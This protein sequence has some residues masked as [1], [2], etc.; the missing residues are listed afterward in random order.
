MGLIMEVPVQYIGENVILGKNVKLWHFTYVGDNTVIGDNTKIG[1]LV[2]VDYDVK[3]GSDCKIEGMAYIPPLTRIGDRV[4]VG[5]GVVFTND[6]YPMSEKLIGV[7]IE[8]DAVICAGAVVRAGIRVGAR[9]VIGM[10]AVVTKEVSPDS[11]V[12]GN[13]ASRRYTKEIYLKKK[14][15]WEK[16][17]PT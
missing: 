1:S 8:D 15:E 16:E 13:P 4:F 10:G 3:I 6:P 12:Y 2:H 5:P 11:V 7:T 9:S 17:A 14:A